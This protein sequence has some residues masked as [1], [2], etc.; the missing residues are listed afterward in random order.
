MQ[1]Y[2][3]VAEG[4]G[5]EFGGGMME[6]Y[7]T[8][9]TM[10][11]FEIFQVPANKALRPAKS[12]WLKLDHVRSLR[13]ALERCQNHFLENLPEQY[14]SEMQAAAEGGEGAA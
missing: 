5:L 3:A 1:C 6:K 11:D 9:D 8:P 12:K 14:Y 10:Q 4:D 13:L 2:L 7:D